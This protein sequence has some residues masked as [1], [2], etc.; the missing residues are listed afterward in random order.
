VRRGHLRFAAA[1]LFCASLGSGCRSRGGE[2]PPSTQ[3]AATATIRA[4]A[5]PDL[6]GA[7]PQVQEHLRQ[8]YAAFKEKADAPGIDASARASAY[9]DLGALLLAAEYLDAAEPCLLN[10]HTMAPGDVRWPYYLGHLHRFKNEPAAAVIWFEEALR[11]QPDDVPAL[12]WLGEE[13]LAENKTD[14]AV[15]PFSK[16]A[17]LDPRSGAARYGQGRVALARQQYRDAVTHLEA[18][19]ALAPAASRVHYPLALAYRGLGDRAKAETHLKLRGDVDLPPADPRM[20]ALGRLLRNAS[21]YETRGVQALNERRWPEAVSN[22]REAIAI[23]PDNAFIH[24][25]LGTAL[26][27]T[28]DAE[29]ARGE[30]E[31]ALRLSPNLPKAHY[32]LGVL[33]EAR[34]HDREAIDHFSAAIAADPQFVE[35]RMELAD[36]LRRSGRAADAL[37]HYQEIISTN[38]GVS[39]ALFGSAMALVRLGRYAEARDRL[40]EGMK[41]YADQPGFA[42]ALARVLAAAPDDRIRDG[43]AA[44]TLVQGLWATQ[45]TVALAE[46]MAMALAETGRFDEAVRWQHDAMAQ[47]A[48][49][50]LHAGAMWA[51]DNLQRYERREP[52]RTPWSADD[53]VFHP[54]PTT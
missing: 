1:A 21:A 45:R 54:R 14:A 46:T 10:A 43:A 9:G 51:A 16:A 5:L 6:S 8:Q 52:C 32:S 36:S 20:D 11:Q 49:E 30:F 27:L 23:D 4:V 7:A 26:Y 2:S 25:N 44:L 13:Y 48:R 28:G 3:S 35:A 37:P 31:T 18:A 12:V 29:T 39:Q 40:A 22:L 38:P 34:G 42:H 47:A 33:M 15:V 41:T 24:L 17:S 19:L 53:P 50:R